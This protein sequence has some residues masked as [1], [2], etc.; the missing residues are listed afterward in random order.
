MTA[1]CTASL[2]HSPRPLESQSLVLLIR[3]KGTEGQ[4]RTNVQGSPTVRPLCFS[5]C[6]CWCEDFFFGV[7]QD[8]HVCER[9]VYLV[10][11]QGSVVYPHNLWMLNWGFTEDLVQTERACSELIDF[12]CLTGSLQTAIPWP[13]RV[14]HYIPFHIFIF[15]PGL[16]WSSLA[17][18]II[19]KLC[20][21]PEKQ[22][23]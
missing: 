12:V 2:P 18:L 6:A 1:A 21:A 16:W 23:I 7:F 3:R 5:S 11:T 8:V 4:A 14:P 13:L 19:R 9:D 17:Q 20:R 10:L 22:H 15:H